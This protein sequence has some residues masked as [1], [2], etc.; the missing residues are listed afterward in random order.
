MVIFFFF[1]LCFQAQST[2]ILIVFLAPS[3]FVFQSHLDLE[4]V[5]YYKY[6]F[7]NIYWLFLALYYI[8][9]FFFFGLFVVSAIV[10]VLCEN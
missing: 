4:I 3:R 10:I 2:L 9:F 8:S 5:L 7:Y 1:N 6:Y